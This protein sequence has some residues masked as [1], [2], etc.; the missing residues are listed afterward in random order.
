V[1][2]RI[3]Q[4]RASRLTGAAAAVAAAAVLGTTQTGLVDVDSLLRLT[5]L[6]D[7]NPFW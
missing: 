1:R 2:K 6:L 5:D 7:L 4:S 3:T